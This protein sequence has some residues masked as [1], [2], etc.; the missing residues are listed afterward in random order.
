MGGSHHQNG[1]LTWAR[2]LIAETQNSVLQKYDIDASVDHRSLKA[3]YNDAL[4]KGDLD[5]ALLLK[6]LPEKHLGPALAGD[7]NNPKVTDLMEY[8]AY[9]F[10]RSKLAKMIDQL[11]LEHASEFAQETKDNIIDTLTDHEIHGLTDNGRLTKLAALKNAVSK[12]YQ[13]LTAMEKILISKES[14]QELALEHILSA[15]ELTIIQAQ[16]KL[17]QKQDELKALRTSL[18]E[19]ADAAVSD[20]IIQA[21]TDDILHHKELADSIAPKVKEIEDKQSNPKFQKQ[22]NNI[23]KEIFSADKFQQREYWRLFQKVNQD[24]HLLQDE[25]DKEII[26]HVNALL[27]V[28]SDITLSTKDIRQY[29]D[30][31]IRCLKKAIQ[32]KSANLE[33]MKKRLIT[34]A[35]ATLIARSRYLK[36]ADKVLRQEFRNLQKEAERIDIAAKE[37]ETAKAEFAALTKPKWYQSN[38]TYNDKVARVL[39]LGEALQKRQQN[40]SDLQEQ[41]NTRETLLKQQCATPEAKSYIVKTAAK[42]LQKNLANVTKAQKIDVPLQ[43]LQGR[44]GDLLTIQAAI[45]A[46]SLLEQPLKL[47]K[48]NT[49]GTSARRRVEDFVHSVIKPHHPAGSGL[50]VSLHKQDNRDFTAMDETEREAQSEIIL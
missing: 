33:R 41:L 7:K 30:N 47:H 34:P 1:W 4:K 16:K 39:A 5:A 2:I 17:T 32:L 31:E 50:S 37:Y 3:Q 29:L 14:A 25:M 6:R 9:K 42:I 19:T 27:D 46:E 21:L 28:D 38:K 12:D 15:P 43:K 24:T 49:G 26:R 48:E 8:R 22:L 13:S 18:L 40:L 45:K 35:R 10:K 44:L 36:G 23:A 11:Q 20:D